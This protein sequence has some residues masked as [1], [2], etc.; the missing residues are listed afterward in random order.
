MTYAAFVALL[1]ATA[2][3]AGAASFWTGLK[4]ANGINYNSA[5]PVA[6]LFILPSTL[7]GE[8]VVQYSVG[9]GFYGSDTHEG[10]PADIIN[11]QSDMDELTQQF[12]RLLREA[13]GVELVDRPGGAVARTPTVREGTKVG[14]GF[15]IDFTVNVAAL[16]C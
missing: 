11:I 8:T 5:F 4:T 6:E 2:L 13:E 3:E 1:E 12:I 14:T 7:V 16:P 15:F 10:S 9:M